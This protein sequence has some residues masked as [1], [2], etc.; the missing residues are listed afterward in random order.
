MGIARPKMSLQSE[1]SISKKR[2][3]FFFWL[4]VL[5][6]PIFWSWFTLSKSFS[7]KERTLAF[8]WLI[9]ST[10]FILA[11]W[12]QMQ[13]HAEL[14]AAGWPL[15]AWLVTLA[16]GVWLFFRLNPDIS[17]VFVVVQTVFIGPYFFQAFVLG[18][19]PVYRDWPSS[20]IW[21]LLPLI[22]IALHLW[23]RPSQAWRLK[24]MRKRQASR[25]GC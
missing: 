4:G 10:T 24:S 22:P 6:L 20:P 7:R 19:L 21:L 23:I 13:A 3:R 18:I 11:R 8:G 14:V 2:S 16:L 25:Q 9:L 15:V 5:V 12:H 17:W 1:F